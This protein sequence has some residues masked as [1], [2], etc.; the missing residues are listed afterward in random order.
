MWELGK[1]PLQLQGVFFCKVVVPLMAK[2]FANLGFGRD[3]LQVWIYSED[4]FF[5]FADLTR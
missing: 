2:G 1:D 3:L 4:G 5:L